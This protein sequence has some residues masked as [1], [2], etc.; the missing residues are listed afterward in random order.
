VLQNLSQ[1]WI[2]ERIFEKKNKL[3]KEKVDLFPETYTLKAKCLQISIALSISL[4]P[5]STEPYH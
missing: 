5:L 4:A 1:T 2:S 3:E